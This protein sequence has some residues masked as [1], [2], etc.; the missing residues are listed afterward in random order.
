MFIY[1][2]A[3]FLLQRVKACCFSGMS[4]NVAETGVTNMKVLRDL[5]PG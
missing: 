1:Y 5:S 2:L 4:H 3:N